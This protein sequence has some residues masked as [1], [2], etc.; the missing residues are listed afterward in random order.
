MSDERSAGEAWEEW[1]AGGPDADLRRAVEA[2]AREIARAQ[3][4][5]EGTTLSIDRLIHRVGTLEDRVEHLYVMRDEDLMAEHDRESDPD[6]PAPEPAT[7]ARVVGYMSDQSWMGGERWTYLYERRQ[8]K[9]TAPVILL[10]DHEEIV[11]RLRLEAQRAEGERDNTH[12]M[13]MEARRRFNAL[14]EKTDEE[15]RTLAAE[16]TGLR[17][18]NAQLRDPK[19]WQ[20]RGE[21]HG[22]GDHPPFRLT[23]TYVG[24]ESPAE[25]EG[26]SDGE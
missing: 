9:A 19:N 6:T 23:A 25:S 18:E 21:V 15:R 11:E 4:E 3:P 1:L 26:V 13:M 8:D 10:S 24:P 14:L 16:I 5:H 12:E 20:V 17:A 7:K 22:S 2:T